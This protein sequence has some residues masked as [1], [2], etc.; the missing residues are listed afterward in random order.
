MTAMFPDLFPAEIPLQSGSAKPAPFSPNSK[1][2]TDT[3]KP[4]KLSTIP[5]PRQSAQ[6]TPTAKSLTYPPGFLP[7]MTAPEPASSSSTAGLTPAVLSNT[8]QLSSQSQISTFRQS[9]QTTLTSLAISIAPLTVEAISDIVLLDLPLLNHLSLASTQLNTDTMAYLIRGRW[10]KLKHL[11]LSNNALDGDALQILS[12][13]S[14]WSGLERLNLSANKIDGG[15]MAHLIKGGK[16]PNLHYLDLG[17]NEMDFL[18]VSALVLG[19]WPELKGL[20]LGSY[21]AQDAVHILIK[22]PTANKIEWPGLEEL[23]LSCNTLLDAGAMSKLIKGQWP[24]LHTLSLSAC[25]LDAS[26]MS[27]LSKGNWQHLRNLNLSGNALDASAMKAMIKYQKWRKMENLN[28]SANKLDV[29][30]FALLVKV[31]WG[32]LKQLD[33]SNNQLSAETAFLLQTA[34]WPALEVLNLSNN[35]LV[36][37]DLPDFAAE[38]Y[39]AAA[40]CDRPY[41]PGYMQFQLLQVLEVNTEQDR[42]AKSH[43]RRAL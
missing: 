22:E 17:L 38:R 12:D 21:I 33:L 28:L 1:A 13:R 39:S 37:S 43:A 36:A 9:P 42:T 34:E 29:D 19:K 25:N 3:S 6:M 16:W 15:A 14:V 10:P 4:A 7:P 18:A 2:V 20:A 11:D 24:W 40:A 26:C 35:E 30:A 8:F 32:S 27:K 5:V 31:K 23:D 41:P